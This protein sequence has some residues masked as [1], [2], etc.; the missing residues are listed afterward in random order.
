VRS[1]F[2]TS[3]TVKITVFWDVML[4]SLVVRHQHFGRMYCLHL[5]SRVVNSKLED[6]DSDFLRKV[7]KDFSD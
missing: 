1:E 2:S 7:D 4:Y 6:D 3:A 5:Q